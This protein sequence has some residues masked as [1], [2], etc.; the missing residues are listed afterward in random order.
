VQVREQGQ[1]IGLAPLC[2][3]GAPALPWRRLVFLGTGVSDYLDLLVPT[4]RARDV[5]MAIVHYLTTAR[6]YDLLDSQD[7]RPTAVLRQAMQSSSVPHAVANAHDIIWRYQEPC[8]SIALPSTWEAYL[9]RLGRKMRQNL[10]YYDRLLQ[11][12][13]EG[14]AKRLTEQPELPEAMKRAFRVAP[15]ELAAMPAVRAP[16][17]PT[18]ASLSPTDRRTLPRTRLAATALSTS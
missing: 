1:L 6:E 18:G 12:G 14:V 9:A 10:S 11:R 3:S 17:K 13:V 15:K 7:L 2:L 5:G 8:L 16:R 4:A